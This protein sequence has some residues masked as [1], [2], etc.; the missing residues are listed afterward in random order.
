MYNEFDSNSSFW[1]KQ[2]WHTLLKSYHDKK[3]DINSPKKL[4]AELIQTLCEN[5]ITIPD[6][7]ATFLTY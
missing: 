7:V 4:S 2:S 5:T 3:Y 6:D 1:G